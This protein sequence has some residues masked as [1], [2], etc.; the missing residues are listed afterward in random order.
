M[1]SPCVLIIRLFRTPRCGVLI[2]S[3][4]FPADTPS[5]Q[6]VWDALGPRNHF[7]AGEYVSEA[8]MD[9]QTKLA[10]E[11]GNVEFV[12]GFYN[13]S[14]TPSLATERHMQQVLL[15]DMDADLYVSTYQALDWVFSNGLIKPG[16]LIGYDDFWVNVCVISKPDKELQL[17]PLNAGE[18][19][20]HKHIS[21]KYGVRFVCIAVSCKRP[22]LKVPYVDGKGCSCHNSWALVFRVAGFDGPD[23]GFALTANEIEE[24][25]LR[26]SDCLSLQSYFRPTN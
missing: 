7:K 3:K 5:Q 11:L 17:S 26:S 22:S 13:E 1:V 16:A 10:K 4:A 24:F 8:G 18:G 19:L 23:H 15:L 12:A 2:V 21:E 9:T 14:L 6:T 20:A 25:R